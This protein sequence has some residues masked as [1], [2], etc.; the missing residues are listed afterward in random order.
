MSN[1]NKICNNTNK[2]APLSFACKNEPT[3]DAQNL[4]NLLVDILEPAANFN[5]YG[6]NKECLIEEYSWYFGKNKICLHK[7][8]TNSVPHL[9]KSLGKVEFGDARGIC[10][11]VTEG[12]SPCFK[13]DSYNES[14]Y[15]CRV[16]IA[17]LSFRFGLD[18]DPKKAEKK[19]SDKKFTHKQARRGDF[20]LG[21]KLGIYN[22]DKPEWFDANSNIFL[23]LNDCN[24]TMVDEIKHAWPEC[25]EHTDN[26]F[27]STRCIR[28]E[29]KEPERQ[30]LVNL[31]NKANID[32]KIVD[33][34]IITK[35]VESAYFKEVD[36]KNIETPYQFNLSLVYSHL[37]E[38]MGQTVE[39]TDAYGLFYE[40]INKKIRDNT[41]K[42]LEDL[43]RELVRD[44][45]LDS[46]A[47][48][49]KKVK[50]T[51]DTLFPTHTENEKIHIV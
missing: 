50:L 32:G 27:P 8:K 35:D 49:K 4:N 39:F 42:P 3:M 11:P 17:G 37:K 7:P 34:H 18:R 29:F 40:Y 15:L 43:V 47:T 31:Y 5:P 13:N 12:D 16:L 46:R 6:G 44:H 28:I 30:T 45:W 2:T 25:V 41:G 48:R 26:A 9:I 33:L 14:N 20:G 24:A 36:Q 10:Y 1:I 22:K 21:V 51:I 23:F 38:W 19:A